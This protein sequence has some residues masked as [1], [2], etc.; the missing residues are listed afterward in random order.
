MKKFLLATLVAFA[1]A[2]LAQA[3][4][5]LF[6]SY[7]KEKKTIKVKES[8]DDKEAK[9]YTVSD[10]IV[11]KNG[12]KDMKAEKGAT[13]LEGLKEGAKFTITLDKENVT[14]LKFVS[15]KPKAADKD[16]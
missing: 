8:K 9:T 13:K 4:E 10:K 7:D 12:D 14:E 6:V 11:Y 2:T 3:G 1:A 15:A 5:V 16:K